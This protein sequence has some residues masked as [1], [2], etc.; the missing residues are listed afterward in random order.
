[1]CQ[2][3]EVKTNTS[4]LCGKEMRICGGYVSN[5]METELLKACL[6]LRPGA[7]EAGYG[8]LSKPSLGLF[9]SNHG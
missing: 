2:T 1:M 3:A 4:E 7:P 8:K 6:R 5:R 9:G